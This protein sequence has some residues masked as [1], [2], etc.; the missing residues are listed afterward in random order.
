[1]YMCSY[2]RAATWELRAV[3]VII[4]Y[5]PRATVTFLLRPIR[6]GSFF[7][8]QFQGNLRPMTSFFFCSH[9]FART[10]TINFNVRTAFT[11]A[12]TRF[13]SYTRACTSQCELPPG[14][15][16]RL[17]NDNLTLTFEFVYSVTRVGEAR[18]L[19]GPFF[20]YLCRRFLS[21][22]YSFYV[23]HWFIETENEPT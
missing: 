14:P 4:I 10:S 21:P 3:I 6:L 22:S 11:R 18:G 8:Q 16:C 2:T 7:T 15:A 9:I 20:L 13:R 17:V 12:P 23:Y 5:V 19:I 1:M